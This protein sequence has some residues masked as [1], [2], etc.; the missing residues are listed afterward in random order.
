[1]H[2]KFKPI[3]PV[4][5]GNNRKNNEVQGQGRKVENKKCDSKCPSKNWTLLITKK[6]LYLQKQIKC[7]KI[8]VCKI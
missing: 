1:M 6:K 5:G 8:N 2:E 7:L 3:Y 4:K